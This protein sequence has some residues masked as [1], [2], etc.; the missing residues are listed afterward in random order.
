MPSR[1]LL[2]QILEGL[3]ELDAATRG[4]RKIQTAADEVDLVG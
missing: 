4:R 3:E 2:R 1:K